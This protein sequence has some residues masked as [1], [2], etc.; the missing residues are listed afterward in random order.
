MR[1]YRRIHDLPAGRLLRGLL[2]CGLIVLMPAVAQEV[3]QRPFSRDWGA[4]GRL[5][6]NGLMFIAL[7]RKDH[8]LFE[9]FLAD[10]W[11]SAVSRE[12]FDHFGHRFETLFLAHH[13]GITGEIRA[14]MER[15]VLPAWRLVEVGVGDARVLEYLADRIPEFRERHGIDLN[16]EVIA[17][18]RR[19]FEGREGY[20]FHAEEVARWLEA[21]PQAGTVMFTHGGVFEYF[22][23]DRL[24]ALFRSL[25]AVGGP[26]VVALTE[27]IAVDH[28]LE[29]GEG[30]HPYGHE[31][32]FSH[33]YPAILREAGFVVSFIRDRPTD[34]GEEHHPARWLQ[35]VAEAAN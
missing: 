27:T 25:R 12:F 16:E 13:R 35:V 21:H 17:A 26:C 6:R 18:N 8:H 33:D 32:S 14:V 22:R 28:D 24:L 34:E 23:R 19:R 4:R 2:G 11:K 10:Y 1:A 9:E 20:H 5:I 7:S 30:S 29:A 15:H 31:L 3:R